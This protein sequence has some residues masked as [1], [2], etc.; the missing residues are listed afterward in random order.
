[1]SSWMRRAAR[2]IRAVVQHDAIDA[3][4]RQR[5]GDERR[6]AIALLQLGER[7][8]ELGERAA[9]A[10]DAAEEHA[11]RARHRVVLLAA[12]ANRLEHL[13]RDVALPFHLH[14]AGAVDVEPLDFEHELVVVDAIEVVIQAP[15]SLRQCASWL[16]DAVCSKAIA[17]HFR[18]I[19][20]VLSSLC[21]RA[22][23]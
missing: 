16:H 22:L 23:P 20:L 9:D 3:E 7:R 14:E 13:G 1:M 2:R 5:Q 19:L 11:A 10:R 8:L 18:R 4:R 21:M 15:G 17:T 6:Y 12:R